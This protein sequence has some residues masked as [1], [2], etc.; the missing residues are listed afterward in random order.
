M[1]L[2]S[3]RCPRVAAWAAPTDIAEGV[4]PRPSL[5]GRLDAPGRLSSLAAACATSA[6]ALAHYSRKRSC[7]KRGYHIALQAAAASEETKVVPGAITKGPKMRVVVFGAS[8]Y[9]GRAV[10]DE[11]QRR[12][13]SVVA[14]TRENA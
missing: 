5:Q 12:G 7:R 1:A 2:P 6:A 3:I 11:L 8:G 10:V 4:N 9:I 13:H 14:F